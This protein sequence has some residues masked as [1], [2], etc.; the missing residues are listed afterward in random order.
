[1]SVNSLRSMKQKSIM[2]EVALY[3]LGRITLISTHSCRLK[4]NTN[5]MWRM[6]THYSFFLTWSVSYFNT[7]MYMYMYYS[8]V[9]FF[10]IVGSQNYEW[11]WYSDMS[12][13]FWDLYFW[14]AH[15][16]HE[17]G[18]FR[19]LERL[20]SPPPVVLSLH[21]NRLSITKMFEILSPF[22]MWWLICLSNCVPYKLSNK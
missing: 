8:I 2:R 14:R 9:C 5:N 6:C 20:N 12:T 1:M 4:A 13:L 21:Y 17:T 7:Y 19:H 11:R 22:A 10:F 16:S 18:E 15:T 3:W